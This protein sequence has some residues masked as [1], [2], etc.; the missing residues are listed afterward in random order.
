MAATIWS[1]KAQS[2]LRSVFAFIAQDDPAIAERTIKR[3][4]HAAETLSQIN[5]GRPGR[6][7]G[8]FEKLV[9][10]LPYFIIYAVRDDEV[11]VLQLLHTAQSY[12]PR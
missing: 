9:T 12:H 7:V 3:I 1:P 6:R 8:T 11:H 5:T 2:Q 4:I 10:G